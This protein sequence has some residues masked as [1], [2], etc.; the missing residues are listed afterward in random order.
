MPSQ[1]SFVAQV[2]TTGNNRVEYLFM[3]DL[4]TSAPD[5]LKSHDL[6][7]ACLPHRSPSRLPTVSPSESLLRQ[8]WAPLR[9]NDTAKPPTIL[10]LVWLDDF[11]IDTDTEIDTEIEITTAGRKAAVAGEHVDRWSALHRIEANRRLCTHSNTFDPWVW[12]LL[13]VGFAVIF[14]GV[15]VALRRCFRCPRKY[16][17]TYDPPPRR[18]GQKFVFGAM[19]LA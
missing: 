13:P 12:G 17:S 10:P 2:P 4:W 16:T 14:M 18:A 15:G 11:E 9:F 5:G 1:N 19:E 7:V 8:Y 3:A 6:Q